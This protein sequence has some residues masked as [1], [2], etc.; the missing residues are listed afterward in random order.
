M[1]LLTNM[2]RYYNINTETHAEKVCKTSE[3]RIKMSKKQSLKLGS[4]IAFGGGIVIFLM[5]LLFDYLPFNKYASAF[6]MIF[7]VLVVFFALGADMKNIPKMIVS[8]ACGLIWGLISNFTAS[9]FMQSAHLLFAFLNYYLIASLMVFIH[10]F[11]AGKTV[12]GC[13]PTAFLGLAESI[14][15]ATCGVPDGTGGL[16]PPMTW[17]P[18]DLFIIFMIGIVMVTLLALVS[19]AIVKAVMK[20]APQSPAKKE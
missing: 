14:F 11:L 2:T 12:F 3:R 19:N 7:V 6:W 20:G 13:A 15:V 18:I 10:Q 9:L 1:E 8:Y 4:G 5:G 16:L 17:G